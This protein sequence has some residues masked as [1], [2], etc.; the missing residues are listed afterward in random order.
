MTQNSKSEYGDVRCSNQGGLERQGIEKNRSRAG[1]ACGN[2]GFQL[3][4]QR[5]IILYDVL[6]Y[7]AGMTG[8]D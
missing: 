3:C 5:T 1:C 2:S 6:Y 7:L 4:G 8:L